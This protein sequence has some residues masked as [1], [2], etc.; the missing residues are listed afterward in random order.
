[1]KFTFK[2]HKAT[3]R[4]RSFEKDCHDIKYNKIACGN[5]TDDFPFYV[6]FQVIKKDINEDGNT[7]CEWKW[8]TL[9]TPEFENIK[10][11]KKWVKENTKRIL[12]FFNKNKTP[13]FLEE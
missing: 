6:K 13:L 11:A 3:G 8:I 4:Y 5:I 7:N 9:K 2:T 1:M 10:E 12:E